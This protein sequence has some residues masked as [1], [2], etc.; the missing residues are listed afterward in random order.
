MK[1]SPNISKKFQKVYEEFFEING[2]PKLA[3]KLIDNFLKDVP[4]YPEALI[5]KARMLI[6]LGKNDKA[7]KVIQSAEKYDKWRLIGKFDKAE[8]Y[9][10]KND[11]NKS[12]AAFINAITLYQDELQNG[13][14]AFFLSFADSKEADKLKEKVF[15]YLSSYWENTDKQDRVI[16]KIKIYLEKNIDKINP[17][18]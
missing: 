12:I 4:H 16:E 1:D 17:Q 18:K 13:I 11:K 3:I 2:D 10:E 15:N 5:F 14:D 7:L 8:A 6:A 9:L